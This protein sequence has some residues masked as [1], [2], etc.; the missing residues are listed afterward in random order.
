MDSPP[1]ANSMKHTEAEYINVGYHFETGRTPGETLRWMIE[2]E[3]IDDRAEARRL[4]E[5]GRAEAR[6]TA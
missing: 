3:R 4:V 5:Q 6:Q 1:G 2:S